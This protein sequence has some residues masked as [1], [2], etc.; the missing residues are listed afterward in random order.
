MFIL[1][2]HIYPRKSF[3]AFLQA[4]S[5]SHYRSD[6]YHTRK[7]ITLKCDGG[8][9]FTTHQNRLWTKTKQPGHNRIKSHH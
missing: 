9:I 1:L 4:F 2:S 6:F 3:I 8:Q 7:K 5:C